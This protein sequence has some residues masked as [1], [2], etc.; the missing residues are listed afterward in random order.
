MSDKERDLI[1]N[2]AQNLIKK[3]SEYFNC[4]RRISKLHEQ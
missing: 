1:D 2:E 4:L 3:T